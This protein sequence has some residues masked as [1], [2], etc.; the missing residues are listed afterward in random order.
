MYFHQIVENI[1]YPFNACNI[2]ALDEPPR[3][4]EQLS[5]GRAIPRTSLGKPFRNSHRKWNRSGGAML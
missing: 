2:L 3:T 5:Y 1:N 4:P